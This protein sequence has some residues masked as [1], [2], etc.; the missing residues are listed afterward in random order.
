METVGGKELLVLSR[1]DNWS[2]TVVWLESGGYKLQQ[3]E[4][5]CEQPWHRESVT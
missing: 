5:K 1:Y 2:G 3:L 4:S